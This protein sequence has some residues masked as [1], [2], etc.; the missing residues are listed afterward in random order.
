[1]VN[2]SY[3]VLQTAIFTS[4]HSIAIMLQYLCNKVDSIV[5]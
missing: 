2:T 3:A 1:M 5:S 4:A